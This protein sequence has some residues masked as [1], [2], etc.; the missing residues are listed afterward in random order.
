MFTKWDERFL[1]VAALVASWSK[2]RSTKVGAVIVGPYNDIRSVGYNGFPRGIDDDVEER[3]G[4]PQKYKWTE[5]A[6]RNAL[7]NALLNHT[8]VAGCTMYLTWYP[9][10]DCAR[11]II[12]SGIFMV[13][14]GKAPDDS[15]PVFIEDFKITHV[16]FEEAHITVVFPE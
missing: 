7:Y 5:H 9:C 13:V 8:P 16:L 6:E 14:C 2:D 15:N 4:R 12:Q 10:A 1:A 11:A 3:H